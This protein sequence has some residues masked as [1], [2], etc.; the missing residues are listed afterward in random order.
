MFRLTEEEYTC[1]KSECDA[2]GGRNLSDYTR[3]ELLSSLHRGPAVFSV[4]LFLDMQRELIEI[5]KLTI[6]ILESV[7]GGS[8]PGNS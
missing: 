7:R 2:A 8:K 5:R 6:Q 3:S 4:R 1:L